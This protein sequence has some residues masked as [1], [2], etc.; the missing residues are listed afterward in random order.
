M[1]G[2]AAYNAKCK[3]MLINSSNQIEKDCVSRKSCDVVLATQTI[4]TFALDTT[5]KK[6]KIGIPQFSNSFLRQYFQNELVKWTAKY[7]A[8]P[9]CFIFSMQSIIRTS[10]YYQKG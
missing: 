7:H 2:S 8:K 6:W 3:N 1:S 9:K 10:E 4:H 5:T